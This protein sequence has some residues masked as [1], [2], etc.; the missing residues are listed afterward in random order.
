MQKSCSLPR[1]QKIVKRAPHADVWR[2]VCACC[3][4]ERGFCT[5][6]YVCV[7]VLALKL[8]LPESIICTMKPHDIGVSPAP[9]T[10]C[11]IL[12]PQ[13]LLSKP[14]KPKSFVRQCGEGMPMCQRSGASKPKFGLEGLEAP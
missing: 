6:V 9:Q 2:N 4:E 3:P 10:R 12:Q 1:S 8:M 5:R 11:P 13:V 14:G 7:F